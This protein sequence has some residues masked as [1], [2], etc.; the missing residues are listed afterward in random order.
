MGFGNVEKIYYS[1]S[2]DVKNTS[3]GKFLTEDKLEVLS[4]C[5]HQRLGNIMKIFNYNVNNQ[6]GSN[7]YVDVFNKNSHEKSVEFQEFLKNQFLSS[8]YMTIK[9]G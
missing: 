4:K 2:I 1:Y 8:T 5:F 6:D 9:L 7:E 3:E